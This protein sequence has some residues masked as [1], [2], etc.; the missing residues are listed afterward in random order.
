MK[1]QR[2]YDVALLCNPRAGGHWRVLS[3]V[4]DRDEAKDA[5]RIVTDDIEDVRE[6]ITGLG[7]RVKLLC[8]YGGDGT[9]HRVVN[10]LLRKQADTPPRLAFLGGGTMNVTAGACGMR[11]SPGDNLRD[12]M[13]AYR[14]DRM[15]WREV[16]L[17]AVSQSGQTRYG[18]SFGLGPLVR[19]LERFE[20]GSKSR[21]GAVRL[22]VQATLA[23]LS[24]VNHTY[25][26]LLRELDAQLTVD[27]ARVP[28]ERFA[29]VIANVTGVINPFVEPFTTERTQQSFYFLAYA[30]STREFA[31]MTPL[32]VRGFLPIDARALLRPISSARRALLSLVGGEGLPVDPRYINHPAQALVVETAEP[33]YTIDGELF[34]NTGAPI[35]VRLGPQL[36]LATLPRR[37]L[38][39]LIPSRL[40][41]AT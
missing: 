27:G 20:S 33:Y 29:A 21:F 5:H 38:A 18:F 26:P 12:V 1:T 31:M 8:I 14:A 16:P 35:E 28:H 24:G 15:L 32:L 3:D 40:K 4:L 25:Q 11:S 23:S 37:G 2:S 13:R 10:E 36:Q 30:V 41:P 34:P 39:R 17:L 9:I 19:L 6:A 7:Q 22:G